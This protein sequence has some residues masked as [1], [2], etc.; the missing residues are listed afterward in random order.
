MTNRIICM[1]GAAMMA[2]FGQES[3]TCT[4]R[5]GDAEGKPIGGIEIEASGLKPVVSD[6][7]GRFRLEGAT[8]SVALLTAKGRGYIPVQ[9][10]VSLPCRDVVVKM[11]TVQTTIEVKAPTD[12]FLATVSVSV[13]KSPMNLLDLPQPVQVLPKALIEDRNIQDIKDLYRNISGV[14]DSPYS[15]MTMRGFT[16]REVLFNG[17]RGNPYGS[18]DNDINDAGF[19]T[20]QGRLTNV[21]FVEVL[22]GPAGVLF[23]GGEPGGVVNFVTR[24]PRRTTTGEASYRMGSF[25]QRGGHGELSGP[26]AGVKNVFYRAAIYGEERKIFRYNSGSENLH[27]ASGLSW[28]MK[29]ATS[30]GFEYEYIDQNLLGHRLRG[31]PVNAAGGW[32]AAREWSAAEPT[33]R[34]ELQAR[35]LQGRLDHGITSTFRT[36]VTVRYLNYDRPERYHEP[37]GINADG[38]TM[39]REYRDQFRGNEDVSLTANFYERVKRN[40]LSFGYEV[41]RQDWAG[42][43]GT[44][45]EAER[46]GPV[47]GIDLLAPVYGRSTRPLINAG[48]YVQQKVLAQR[49]GLFVQDQIEVSPRLQ[50]LFGGR[51]ERFTDEGRAGALP[52]RAEVG[53]WTGRAAAVYRLMPGLAAYASVSN[54]FNRAPSL[55]QTPLAN[56]PHDPERGRQLE[57]GVKQE[58]SGGRILVNAAYFRIRKTNV[59]RLDPNFGPN[60]DNFAAVFPIGVVRNQGVEMDVTGKVTKNL[61][62]IVNYALLDSEILADRFTAAA[63]GKA[64]PNVA[65]HAGGVFVRYDYERT[66]TSLHV[67]SEARG[68]RFEPY[69]GFAAGGYAVF[70]VGVFQKIGPR[71]ELR[72]QLDN[73]FDRLYGTASLFAARAGNMPGAPRTASIGLHFVARRGR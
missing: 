60:G 34:S 38:R 62:V 37:R 39:R 57:V 69:A 50:L 44:A 53:A 15:A 43:Y 28:K 61:S 25:A 30:L 29:E 64:L 48:A 2:A 16:Q 70:D 52:L 3:G 4:G 33:D 67:G 26:L 65:R 13:T 14:Q 59:L 47:P 17:V 11:E 51:W 68:R 54:N 21:E 71:L 41:V 63:V 10:S 1:V 12:D 73:A 40:N 58:L 45:R 55:A 72:A 32:L 35:V 56:G 22:K 66:G 18:L 42:R 31:I 46:G 6:G 24:K 49:Q 19:S 36:D 8:G 7:E 5:V 23:G 20:S 27:F 9:V